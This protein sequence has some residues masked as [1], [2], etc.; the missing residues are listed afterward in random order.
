MAGGLA[1]ELSQL[2]QLLKDGSLT[3]QEFAAAKA[4]VL[5]QKPAEGD[6]AA[7]EGGDVLILESEDEGDTPLRRSVDLGGCSPELAAAVREGLVGGKA[8]KQRMVRAFERL[9][10]ARDKV[11]PVEVAFHEIQDKGKEIW[12]PKVKATSIY[13]SAGQLY[14]AI[15][16]GY[17]GNQV[18]SETLRLDTDFNIIDN[19]NRKRFGPDDLHGS[20]RAKR[21]ARE[22]VRSGRRPPCPATGS[23]ADGPGTSAPPV[24]TSHVADTGR[25]Y[26]FSVHLTHDLGCGEALELVFGKGQSLPEVIAA[27]MLKV[28]K[29]AG[30]MSLALAQSKFQV[31]NADT[32]CWDALRSEAQLYN[33]VHVKVSCSGAMEAQAKRQRRDT[34]AATGSYSWLPAFLRK[35]G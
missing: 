11:I 3:P 14:L 18:L 15:E 22:V 9:H 20:L 4:L 25:L 12:Y 17:K 30:G 6:D 33:H 16:V 29:A 21:Q 23:A 34:A 26:Y 13:A 32:R 8:A 31:Y 2:A 19:L 5:H 28:A 10:G 27:C 7:G 35:E 24:P 1:A